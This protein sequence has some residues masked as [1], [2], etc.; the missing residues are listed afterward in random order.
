MNPMLVHMY[1]L[2]E[3]KAKQI[4]RL[5]DRMSVDRFCHILVLTLENSQYLAH[6]SSS[7]A[8]V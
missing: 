4:T 5:T 8:V 6:V 7:V 3:N 1:R 2:I